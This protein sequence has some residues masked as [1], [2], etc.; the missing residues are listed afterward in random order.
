MEHR[1]DYQ[2]EAA[3]LTAI[4]GKL[5]CSPDIL[6]TW[7]RQTQRDGGERSGPTSAEIAR[8]EPLKAPFAA[9]CPATYARHV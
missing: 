4:A 3:A 9:R 7:V 8:S 6:R 1:D 5:W 2:S